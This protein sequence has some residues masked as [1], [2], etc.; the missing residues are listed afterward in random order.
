MQ[1]NFVVGTNGR[2]IA[3][4]RSLGFDIVGR[5]PLAFDHPDLG[6]VDAFVMHRML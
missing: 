4:W 3:L 2:A 6:L 5:L 1:F